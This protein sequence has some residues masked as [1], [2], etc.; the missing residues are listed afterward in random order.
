MKF[1]LMGSNAL[2]Q[3]V[4]REVTAGSEDDARA[5]A[6]AEGIT[7]EAIERVP[8]AAPAP[9]R[10]TTKR[11]AEVV[12]PSWAASGSRRVK[13]RREP[14]WKGVLGLALLVLALGLGVA[15]LLIYQPNGRGEAIPLLFTGA[16]MSAIG[17]V[18][19]LAV[20]LG[21]VLDGKIKLVIDED[22]LHDLQAKPAARYR[23]NEI[24]GARHETRTRNGVVVAETVGL[25]ILAPAG[26]T[27]TVEV[28]FTK[29]DMTAA[30]LCRLI[31]A[32]AAPDPEVVLAAAAAKG[33][34]T[35]VGADRV[36]RL[37]RVKP[38]LLLMTGVFLIAGAVLLAW[39]SDLSSVSVWA[40]GG[41][42]LVVGFGLIA[43]SVATLRKS[44]PRLILN[45]T[46][47][48]DCTCSPPHNVIPWPSVAEVSLAVKRG[49]FT[50]LSAVITVVVREGGAR[51]TFD[52]DVAG[53]GGGG[54]EGIFREIKK[55]AGL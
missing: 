44:S 42:V 26:G 8:E 50:T 7:V 36:Y 13:R 48:V 33:Q 17:A 5:L 46:G 12:P 54:P 16:L 6:A 43:A 52:L 14:G 27:R 41:L 31:A 11:W 45:D 38:I 1:L 2:G 24:A 39:V 40:T 34:T 18:I 35:Q 15:C 23:W 4:T 53:L 9:A 49:S 25:H 19:F 37:A 55:R 10:P 32:L 29:M 22:G 51:R 20:Y 47:I 3:G 28:P 21:P 30:D